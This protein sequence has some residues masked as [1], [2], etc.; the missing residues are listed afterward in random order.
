MVILGT[1]TKLIFRRRISFPKSTSSRWVRK[2][3]CARK[4]A[5]TLLNICIW[6]YSSS[7]MRYG[8]IIGLKIW[9]STQLHR[10]AKCQGH[11][12]LNVCLCCQW[13]QAACG[14][15]VYGTSF[16][17]QFINAALGFTDTTYVYST[18]ND[19]QKRYNQTVNPSRCLNRE[20][21]PEIGSK[22]EHSSKE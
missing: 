19:W 1:C 10:K 13:L 15:V 4:K 20:T 21:A 18:Q 11:I 9:I 3:S 14:G 22:Y 6:I 12:L 17:C 7:F 8:C 2:Q 5:T 16:L